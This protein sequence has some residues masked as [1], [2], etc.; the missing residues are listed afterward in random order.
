MVIY[1][2]VL[3]V[4]NMYV[5][6][7]ILKLTFA[8]LKVKTAFLRLI[9]ASLLGAAGAFYILLPTTN[10]LSDILFRL[11]MS[12]ALILVAA[13]YK[14]V[15]ILLRQVGV[16]FAASFLY[17]GVMIGLWAVFKIKTIAVK[18]GVVY[19]DISPAVLIISTLI[20][21]I[22][23]SLIR[24]FTARQAPLANRCSLTIM[25]GQKMVT[26]T[27]IIDTGH[28]LTDAITGKSVVV[29]DSTVANGLFDPLPTINDLQNCP[30]AGFRVV[31]YSAVGGHGLLVA[32]TPGKITAQIGQNNPL[33]INALCAVTN[34]PLGDDYSAII[35]PDAL[36]F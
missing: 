9:L 36:T 18:G 5:N 6:F 20:C 10:F 3:F 30:S 24:F 34:E 14:N 19:M 12:L 35:S 22:I 15:K 27:A 21:Y 32:F 1:A 26:A 13:G 17:A 7:F 33:E 31:P 4:L 23:I 2:D 25:A 28:S 8:L 16:F 29:I 11:F